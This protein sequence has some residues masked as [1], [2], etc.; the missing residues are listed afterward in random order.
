MK[1]KI[2]LYLSLIVCVGLVFGINANA[3]QTGETGENTPDNEQ[4]KAAVKS[5]ELIKQLPQP[6]LQKLGFESEL[7]V[8]KSKLGEPLQ[9]YIIDQV[10]LKEFK[11]GDEPGDI[12]VDINKI[13]YPIYV[14]GGFKSSITLRKV[15]K[16]WR[17]ASMGGVETRYSDHARKIHSNNSQTHLHSYFMVQVPFLR[18]TF[19]AYYSDGLLYLLS[20]HEDPDFKF[21]LFEPVL[22]GGVYLQLKQV[23]EKYR[24]ELKPSLTAAVEDEG[25]QI[26]RKYGSITLFLE[27]GKKYLEPDEVTTLT[28]KFAGLES[29]KGDI[30]Y[31]LENKT[32]AIISMEDGN[33]R[34]YIIR[35]KDIKSDG[36]FSKTLTLTGKMPGDFDI[37]IKMYP[38]LKEHAEKLGGTAGM[39]Y[40]DEFTDL[41]KQEILDMPK[42]Q[43]VSYMKKELLKNKTSMDTSVTPEMKEWV[44]EALEVLSS[45]NPI[46]QQW[47]AGIYMNNLIKRIN[48]F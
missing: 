21:P 2:S 5:L 39:K 3:R 29:D 18:L 1:Y 8:K 42:S 38:G 30:F 48:V 43:Y 36:T 16:K 34:T 9:V 28:V 11:K 4:E 25:I 33:I 35:V 15:E 26:S 22:A 45:S 20:T 13:K 31:R 44:D 10:K 40:R 47:L 19:L 46:L 27:I 32:P 23:I 37:G 7:V 17:F 6:V 24:W 14:E 12:L 41:Q